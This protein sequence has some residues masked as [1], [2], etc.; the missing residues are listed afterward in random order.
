MRTFNKRH[1]TVYV[2]ENGHHRIML[3]NGETIPGDIKSHVVDD[4]EDLA[5]VRLTLLANI[6]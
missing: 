4:L 2:D 6:V 5:Q 1:A 3:P